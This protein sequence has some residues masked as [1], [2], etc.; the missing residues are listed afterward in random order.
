MRRVFFLLILA[1]L[2][3]VAAAWLAD[4]P[5]RV[6]MDWRGWRLEASA[7]TLGVLALL[8]IGALGALYRL[9]LWLRRDTPFSAGRRHDRRQRKGMAALTAGFNAL[10]AG[11]RK[12]ALK[13]AGQADKLLGGEPVALLL[14]AQAAEAN[15]DPAAAEAAFERLAARGDS[16]V[17][18]LRGLIG[19]ALREDDVR[20][21]RR[22]LERAPDKADASPWAERLR[23]DLAVRDGAWEEAEEVFRRLARERTMDDAVK[24]RAQAGLL[25]AR[26]READL[27]GKPDDAI[28]LTRRAIKKDPGFS[29][30]AVLAARLLK[31]DGRAPDA[32]GVLVR[33]WEAAPAPTLV[34]TALSGHENDSPAERMRRLKDLVRRAPDHVE[35]RLARAALALEAADWTEAR[36][37]LEATLKAGPSRRACRMLAQLERAQY[38]NEEA[39]QDWLLEAEGAPEDGLWQC[40]ACGAA[41]DDWTLSCRACGGFATLLWGGTGEAL[42]KPPE[43]TGRSLLSGLGQGFTDAAR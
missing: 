23:F 17:L 25:Y 30:A 12:Q 2:V 9:L 18:G 3:G 28:A 40:S 31:A 19:R 20:A 24:A 43:K 26:A 4:E 22:L 36:I 37:E 35:A 14:T 10:A 13:M 38:S 34:E 27:A 33:A 16:A 32:E 29:A 21:A 5:G 42:D 6:T 41:R 7:A 1:I 15:N 11:N 39:A 8:A